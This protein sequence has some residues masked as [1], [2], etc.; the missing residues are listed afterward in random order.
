MMKLPRRNNVMRR[1]L[2][3]SRVPEVSTGESQFEDELRR[4]VR[5]MPTLSMPSRT[6]LAYVS[7]LFLGL[8]GNLNVKRLGCP[9]LR[10]TN[11]S[12]SSGLRASCGLCF[13]IQ[14][15][16]GASKWNPA[17]VNFES[18]DF[19]V[20]FPYCR[21]R[22]CT[23]HLRLPSDLRSPEKKKRNHEPRCVI[24]ILLWTPA[25][26]LLCTFGELN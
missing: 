15:S 1:H 7:N 22:E 5:E 9:I 10:A 21:R 13:F 26:H 17:F 25:P 20:F 11:R 8:G 14:V 6:Y 23:R 2:R 3:R 4:K 19:C 12:G 18:Y 24:D 16:D